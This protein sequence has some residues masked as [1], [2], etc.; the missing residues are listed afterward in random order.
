MDEDQHFKRPVVCQECTWTG[1]SGATDRGREIAGPAVPAL[2]GQ[3]HQIR[4]ADQHRHRSI[5]AITRS[6]G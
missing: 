6:I 2:P 5:T 4:D 3:L 1:L